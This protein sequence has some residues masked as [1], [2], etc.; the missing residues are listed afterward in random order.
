MEAAIKQQLDHGSTYTASK[1]C[2][3]VIAEL[4]VLARLDKQTEQLRSGFATRG[5][6][7][8]AGAV[9]FFVLAFPTVG[10]TLIL[11]IP[12]LIYGIHQ[13]SQRSGLTNYDVP[14]R[15]YLAPLNMLEKLSVDIPPGQPIDVK[16]DFNHYHDP[17]YEQASE[18]GGFFSN[19]KRGKYEILWFELSGCLME[20]TKF[21][22][23]IS[24]NIK[25]KSK[26]KKS[27]TKVT[28]SLREKYNLM[29][30]P[31]ADRYMDLAA[32]PHA[33]LLQKQ[34]HDFFDG[35]IVPTPSVDVRDGRVIVQSMTEAIRVQHHGQRLSEPFTDTRCS[36]PLNLF[37]LS[38]AGLQSIK[39]GVKN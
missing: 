15:Q 8:I 29:L 28:E 21:R 13:L 11:A 25:R 1:S 5:G 31:A 32:F 38:F 26:T 35:L 17:K 4:R 20:G 16:I 22:V 33:L 27:G 34:A 7:S 36:F 6:F 14:D 2:D 3:E 19:V 30:I 39:T 23:R 12:L 24:Q 18:D 9:I 10:L 37:R